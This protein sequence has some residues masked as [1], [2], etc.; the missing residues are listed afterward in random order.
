LLFPWS[1]IPHDKED[2]EYEADVN[3]SQGTM[4]SKDKKIQQQSQKKLPTLTQLKGKPMLTLGD[5]IKSKDIVKRDELIKVIG[6]VLHLCYWQV[7]G[8][9][10]PVQPDLLTRKQMI[11]T[12][13]EQMNKIRKEWKVTPDF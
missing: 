10:V 3:A 11:I 7:F 5:I 6:I 4:D 2:D 12:I 8:H 13:M 9:V 1:E